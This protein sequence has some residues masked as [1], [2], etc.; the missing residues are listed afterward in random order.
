MLI[1]CKHI[2]NYTISKNDGYIFYADKMYP[3]G[4]KSSDRRIKRWIKNIAPSTNLKKNI[5]MN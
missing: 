3:R 5:I 1:Q 4:L 2:Y